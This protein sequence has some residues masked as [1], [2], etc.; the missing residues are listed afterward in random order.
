MVL[1]DYRTRTSR[2][3]LAR[4]RDKAVDDLA[5]LG[6]AKKNVRTQSATDAKRLLEEARGKMDRRKAYTQD[7]YKKG[8]ESHNSKNARELEAGNDL[9]HIKWK[10]GKSGGHIFYDKPN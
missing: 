6:K 5:N 2:K 4:H 9:Q 1:G 7:N 3:M 8:Y 10:D